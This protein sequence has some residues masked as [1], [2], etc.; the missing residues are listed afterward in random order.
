[1]TDAASAAAEPLRQI[2]DI[3]AVEAEGWPASLPAS[4]YDLLAGAAR[5]FADQPAIRFMLSG[6]DYR[7]VSRISYRQLFSRVTQAANLFHSLGVGPDDAVA[8]ILPNL[9]E[10]HYGLWGG[11]AA[12]AALPINPLLEPELITA[13]L[14]AS[15]ARVV[16]TL[17]PFPGTDLHGKVVSAVQGAPAV[18][19]L[20]TVALSDHV[21][22]LK[23]LPARFMQARARR[24]AARVRPGVGVQD[25]VRA[26]TRHPADRLVSGR[27]I[28]PEDLS[29]I[30]CT[31]GTTGAPKLARRTHAN[32]VANTWMAA[33]ALAGGLE[34]GHVS[35]CGLP[36]F[37]VNGALVTGLAAFHVGA[38]VVLGSP[39]GFRGPGIV[40]NFWKIVEHHRIRSLSGVPTLFAALLQRPTEG[41]ELSSLQYAICG[42]APMSPE[43]IQ[44]FETTTGLTLLE[45][46]GMTEST[47]VVSVNPLMG[48]RRAGSVGLPLPFQEIRIAR[49]PVGGV[50]H[51]AEAG[52]VGRVLVR[53]PATFLGYVDARHESGLWVE[54]DGQRWLDTGD[55][56]LVDND[57]YLWLKGRSKD[58]IIRGGH[59]ID[60]AM[61]EEAFF[62]HPAVELAA[63]IGRPDEHAGEV[64]VVYVKLKA[65][66]EADEAALMAFAEPH[67]PER[68]ARPKAVVVLDDMPLTAVGKVFKPRLRE[69][70]A[71]RAG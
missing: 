54:L 17:A 7:R 34:P 71:D 59:N 37:H 20:L 15:G 49:D 11:E 22:G 24:Q 40:A 23:R 53:G 30:F 4:T 43:L 16:V 18:E 45:G 29:S 48:E 13:I 42:A 69:L 64:P 44:Q 46:Y 60:P 26:L 10:M 28:A 63:A 33:R 58:L 56:G 19:H 12:G 32:E 14:N 9:P 3:R 6:E 70:E 66:A 27:T 21:L 25:F 51:P 65:G 39:Q 38:E 67:I 55:L 62:K 68:A 5:R 31:G 57:G 8:L 47:C 36:L 35:F 2:A 52:E 50:C 1:M 41:R 61:I